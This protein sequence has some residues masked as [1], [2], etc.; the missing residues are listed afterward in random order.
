MGPSAKKGCFDCSQVGET[1]GGRSAVQYSSKIV[2]PL[3]T[4]E[5]FRARVD[6]GHHHPSHQN[7]MGL[8][9]SIGLNMSTDFPICAMHTVDLGIMKKMLSIIIGDKGFG[10]YKFKKEELKMMSDAYV[11]LKERKVLETARYPRDLIT[12]SSHFKATE[13]RGVLLYY[14][15]V[16]LKPYLSPEMYKHFLCL[17][18]GIRILADSSA[19][20]H[21]KEIA[22][23]LLESFVERFTVYYGP[24]RSFVVHMLLHLKKYVDIHGPLYSFSAYEFENHLRDV[25]YDVHFHHKV[26]QQLKRR[27]TERGFLK[28]K[29]KR[30][31]GLGRRANDG[32]FSQLTTK[33]VVYRCDGVNS[34]AWVKEEGLLFPV[35]LEKFIE[36]EDSIYVHFK[37]LVT[38]DEPFFSITLDDAETITSEMLNI[39]YCYNQVHEVIYETTVNAIAFK[40]IALPSEEK[41]VV[42]PLLH[43]D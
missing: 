29:E 22:Q 13:C 43:E 10:A 5:S 20:S 7:K 6:P 30:K 21:G 19:N 18:I 41:L 2:Y 33:S 38:C 28:T 8:L 24:R 36:R 42:I 37:K 14:G 16:F 26:I 27:A 1:S 34:F 25:K 15:I 31:E 3:R 9:E 32:S 17:A 40:G 35:V 11:S 23:R 12:N 4:D 39:A